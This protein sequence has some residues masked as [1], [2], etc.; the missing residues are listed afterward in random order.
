[1]GYPTI[2]K[3]DVRFIERT[4]E[5]VANFTG[6]N[7]FT[8]LL[9]SLI[10]LIFIPHEF[11]KKGRFF[12]VDFLDKFISDYVVLG[13][14]FSGNV[15]IENDRGQN[16]TQNKF[17]YKDNKGQEQSIETTKLRDLVRLFRNSIAHQNITPVAEGKNWI[18]IIVRNYKNKTDM[19]NGIFNF[20][21][22]LNQK[23]VLS[24]ATLISTE[25]LEN[26]I[27]KNK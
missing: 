25:Y 7:K 21:V 6:N 24:F 12:K 11:Y 1:M 17:Y 23:E 14:I 22:Y 15:K 16:I 27:P 10:G 9:N 4:K 3:F 26:I 5:N 13:K 2:E 8:H 20:E 18:G 19:A